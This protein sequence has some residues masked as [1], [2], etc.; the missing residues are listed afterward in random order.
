MYLNYG[1]KVNSVCTTVS[2][3]QRLLEVEHGCAQEARMRLQ[4]HSSGA[5]SV[6]R[7]QE[8]AEDRERVIKEL[9]EQL[10]TG[11]R[12]SQLQLQ[13]STKELQQVNHT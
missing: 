7:L 1:V 9:A 10:H 5:L 11:R 8:E 13:H 3:S 6:Q 4:L 2:Q 12:H